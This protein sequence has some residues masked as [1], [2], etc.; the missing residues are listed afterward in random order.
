MMRAFGAM[1]AA[2]VL[3]TT[4]AA[5]EPCWTLDALKRQS[6][7]DLDAIFARATCE[8]LPCGFARGT[9]VRFSD[10]Y[11][12]PK[13]SAALSGAAWKGKHFQADGTFVNQF[14]GVKAIRSCVAQGLSWCDGKPAIVLEYAPGTPLFADMRD[15]VRRVGPGLYL[16]R[17]YDRD[18]GAF[19]GYVALEFRGR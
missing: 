13:L 5:Q 17:L 6:L 10:Y 1:A 14:A 9:I 8:P 7:C 4:A 19:R 12:C 15:E 16:S 3:C 11:R 18:N 2:L